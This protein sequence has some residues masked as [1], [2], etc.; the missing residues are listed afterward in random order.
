MA[1]PDEVRE[2]SRRPGTALGSEVVGLAAKLERFGNQ[3]QVEAPALAW[4]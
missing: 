1:C 3:L 2:T 4:L